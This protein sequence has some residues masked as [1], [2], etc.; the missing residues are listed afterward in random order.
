MEK[1]STG[2]NTEA[3]VQRS[4]RS[5]AM[6][7]FGGKKSQNKIPDWYKK[8]TTRFTSFSSPGQKYFFTMSTCI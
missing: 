1:T 5:R 6:I 7:V 4:D 8:A 3:L 2:Q